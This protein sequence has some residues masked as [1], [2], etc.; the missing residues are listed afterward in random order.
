MIAY[1][2]IILVKNSE[3]EHQ[4]LTIRLERNLV[5]L[6]ISLFNK[7]QTANWSRRNF[8]CGSLYIRN[9]NNIEEIIS[10]NSTS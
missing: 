5:F 4:L 7:K 2:L 10:R 3:L 1:N 9:D 8:S 6:F